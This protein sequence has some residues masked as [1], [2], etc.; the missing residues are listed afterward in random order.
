M[1]DAGDQ[2]PVHQTSL[3]TYTAAC[4][5]LTK[6]QIEIQIH[7]ERKYKHRYK[8]KDK[9]DAGDQPGDNTPDITLDS[10]YT[11]AALQNTET[12]EGEIGGCV[13]RRNCS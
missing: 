13:Q 2:P 11:A 4:C 9:S 12:G 5:T 8:Y 6:I 10:T 3:S 7:Y 1:S